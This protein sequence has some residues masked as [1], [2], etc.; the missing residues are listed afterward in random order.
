MEINQLYEE[1]KILKQTVSSIDIQ[2]KE[3][4][5][6]LDEITGT[7]LNN[8]IQLQNQEKSLFKTM[9]DIRRDGRN[10]ILILLILLALFMIFCLF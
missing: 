7:N 9:K 5:K 1:S 6:I 8:R 4:N 3:Q 10:T 2:V